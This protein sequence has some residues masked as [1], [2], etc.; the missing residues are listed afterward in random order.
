MTKKLLKMEWLKSSIVILLGTFIMAV[1]INAFIIPHNLL[2]GGVSGIAI[3][4]QYLTNIS[5][6]I[7]VL[8]LNI[9]IFIFGVKEIN[10]RF[11]FLSLV[12]MVSSSIFL[13]LTESLSET[14]WI[15]DILASS[16]YSGI[17]IGFS[18]GI[19]FRVRAST[20]GTDIISVIMKKKFE[21]GISSILFVMNVIIVLIGSIISDYTLA[22]YTLISMF[23]SSV[24]MNKIIIGLDTK[25]LVL[26]ITDNHDEMSKALMDRVK[27]GVTFLESEGAYSGKKKKVVYCVISTRQLSVVKNIVIETDPQAFMT[28]MDTAE[29]H[30]SGFKKPI[31]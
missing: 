14:V 24:V 21:I 29:I 12:G 5:T 2:S 25:K 8:L 16:I 19:I 15:E 22:I 9:P 18:S 26:I 10:K 23:I 27:R 11:A 31:F 28:V 4:L 30:G 20:G 13:I 17:F 6:G 3:I 1:G 7:F